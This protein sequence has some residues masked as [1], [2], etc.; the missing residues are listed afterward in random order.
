MAILEI[1][2]EQYVRQ[3]CEGCKERKF[4]ENPSHTVSTTYL[5]CTLI[6]YE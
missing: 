1:I 6:Y 5:K 3:A 2:E 4:N